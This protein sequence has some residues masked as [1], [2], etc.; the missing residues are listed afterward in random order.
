MDVT[1][2]E[3]GGHLVYETGDQAKGRVMFLHGLFFTFCLGLL[4]D[5]MRP[6]N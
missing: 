2:H 1:A 6:V 5:G 4:N 3:K